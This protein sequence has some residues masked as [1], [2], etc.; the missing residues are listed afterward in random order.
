MEQV[1]SLILRI[2]FHIVLSFLPA[3]IIASITLTPL[4]LMYF[5]LI[6]DHMYMEAMRSRISSGVYQNL[7]KMV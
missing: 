5:M 3:F 4:I 7:G 6:E 1:I 2:K